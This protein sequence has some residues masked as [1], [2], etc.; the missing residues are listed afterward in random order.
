MTTKAE[1]MAAD[2]SHNGSTYQRDN[3]T[4]AEVCAI[5]SAW[6]GK[7]VDF[8]AIGTNV[9]I[10]F[11]TA[12]TVD[13][14]RTTASARDGGTKALTATTAGAHLVIPDGQVRSERIDASWTHFAHEGTAATGQLYM[15]LSTGDGE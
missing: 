1:R 5:P 9:F 2:Y 10:R 7:F 8:T 12:D 11:G 14:D 13:L 3:V 4:T 6:L 15:A